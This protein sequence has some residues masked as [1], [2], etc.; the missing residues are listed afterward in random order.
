MT[1]APYVEYKE[2]KSGRVLVRMPITLHEALFRMAQG[3]G[4]SMNQF[5]CGVLAVAVEW[6]S[7]YKPDRPIQQLRNDLEWEMWRDR[8]R[9]QGGG[10]P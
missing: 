8:L 10:G 9:G 4:V 5:I 7:D 3:E 6:R 1:S 2:P